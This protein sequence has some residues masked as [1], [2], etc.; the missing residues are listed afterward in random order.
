MSS[1]SL[2]AASEIAALRDIYSSTIG[3]TWFVNLQ[4]P[5]TTQTV[6]TFNPCCWVGVTCVNY[7]GIGVRVA[8]LNLAHNN[9][10]GSLPN[11]IGQLPFLNKLYETTDKDKKCIFSDF[12][13]LSSFWPP[14]HRFLHNNKI[15][16]GLPQSMSSLT[17]LE[18]L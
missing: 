14:L 7:F 16:G 5:T 6:P 15:A 9:L 10:K 11:S 2:T 13:F 3:L 18:L 1:L 4:W 17:R 8:E 12:F